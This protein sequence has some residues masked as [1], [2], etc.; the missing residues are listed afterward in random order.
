MKHGG[1]LEA[2]FLTFLVVSTVSAD[3]GRIPIAQQT[4]ITAPGEYVLTRDVTATSGVTIDIDADGVVLDLNGYELAHENPNAPVVLVDGDNTI[5]RNGRISG[6]GRAIRHNNSE[7]I[8]LRVENVVV[9]GAQYGGVVIDAVEHIEVISSR[10]ENIT[11]GPAI[12]LYGGSGGFSGR[13]VNNTI[14]GC[15]MGM[16]VEGIRGGEIRDN[17]IVDSYSTT[18][19]AIFILSDPA[20]NAGGNLLA[21]NL[22]RDGAYTGI[23]INAES[24]DNIIEGNAISSNGDTGIAISSDGNDVRRNTCTGNANRGI[25]ILGSQN[26]IR[27][28]HTAMNTADGIA[29]AGQH[30]LVENN[31]S[32]GNGGAGIAFLGAGSGHAH[33]GNMLRGNA[34]GAVAGAGSS[35]DAGG[36]I[37]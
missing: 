5:I 35:T 6:G 8:R 11:S 29:I 9:Q 30:Q 15:I 18:L 22:I 27:E 16:H 10:F 32:E 17:V 20:W 24:P 4:T 12:N 31:L 14:S 34:G 36:N 13:I 7:R 2:V 37:Q 33:R 19:P 3:G 1:M 23:A 26:R 21:G 28:N 25:S